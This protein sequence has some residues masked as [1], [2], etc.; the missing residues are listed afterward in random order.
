[1]T[2]QPTGAPDGVQA[3]VISLNERKQAAGLA[4]FGHVQLG[5]T[6]NLRYALFQ[7]DASNLEEL[8]TI[9]QSVVA[10]AI[11]PLML[12]QVELAPVL[13][14]LW[15]DGIATGRRWAELKA[16]LNPPP[17]VRYRAALRQVL[18]LIDVDLTPVEDLSPDERLR[19]IRDVVRGALED[20]DE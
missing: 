4:P 12:G 7:D 18:T 5:D 9:V 3:A 17:G 10:T 2:D 1:M 16:E 14:G 6:P 11:G 15:L 19:R 8:E 20:D 13:G